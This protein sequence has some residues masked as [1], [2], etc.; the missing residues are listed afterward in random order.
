MRNAFFLAAAATLA[1]P[2]L[3]T[4]QN[5]VEGRVGRL[6]SEMRAVQRKVFPGGNGQLLQPEVTAP[7]TPT[8]A[9]GS[10]S[11]SAVIDLSARVTALEQ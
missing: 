6:E 11:S 10:P 3:A 8:E 2:T 1:L 7:T 9:P 4:A 5:N